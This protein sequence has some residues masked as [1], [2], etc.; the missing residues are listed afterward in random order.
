MGAR[1]HHPDQQYA[2]VSA[3]MAGSM[4]DLRSAASLQRDHVVSG[5]QPQQAVHILGCSPLQGTALGIPHSELD[6]SQL[7]LAA[8]EVRFED[9]VAM[10]DS[11]PSLP[12]RCDVLFNGSQQYVAAQHQEL[13]RHAMAQAAP[14][15]LH[16]A[17]PAPGQ[18]IQMA[19]G[20]QHSLDPSVQQVP[21]YAL[22]RI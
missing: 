7:I 20:I 4:S 1:Q 5:M 17:A 21:P 15:A 11:Q 14:S 9:R 10:A 19:P 13:Q 12:E 16:L 18:L 8:A 2:D 22:Q 3:S 6:D